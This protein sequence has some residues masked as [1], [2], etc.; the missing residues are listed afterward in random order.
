MANWQAA[1]AAVL[2]H[3]LFSIGLT[4][5]G[6]Q[7]GTALYKRFNALWVQPFLVAMTLVISTLLLCQIPYEEYR[8]H[9]WVVT[10][11]LG[12]A[13]VALAVPLFLN[14]T[15][16]Q[17]LF[18]PIMLT[19]MVGGAVTTA[20]I[21]LLSWGFGLSDSL[22]MT[23][24]PKSVTSPIAMLVADKLGGVAALTAVFVLLTGVLGAMVGPFLL[25]RFRIT[26]PAAR[27]MAMGLTAHAVGT[28]QALQEN[29]ECGA[30]AA[31]AMSLMGVVTAVFLPL[32]VALFRG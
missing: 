14:L 11:F 12:P 9:N 7:V 30:F 19:L 25:T 8:Q 6:Y 22:L 2:H 31:M 4:L 32:V 1:E 18:Q 13:T 16:I 15:R 26:H 3:P 5:V 17:A 24:A 28:A 23:L 27:G 29:E 10:V 21:M 20:L